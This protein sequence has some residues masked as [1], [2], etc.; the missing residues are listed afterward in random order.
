M[1]MRPEKDEPYESWCKRVQMY[2]QGH[3]M[4]QVAQGKNV[5]EVME[6]MARRIT[7][8]L[9]HPLFKAI[10]ESDTPFDIEENKRSYK[11]K[12]LDLNPTGVADHVDTDS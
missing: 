10:Q 1:G 6:T 12:Y 8:K 5:E 9:L 7:D 11:E 3:A 4:M 2:E